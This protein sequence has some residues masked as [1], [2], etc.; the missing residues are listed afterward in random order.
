MRLNEPITNREVEMRDGQ[1]LV[2]QTDAGGRIT[3]VN[4]AFIDI[5]GFSEAEL[6]GQPHNLVRHPHMPKE[7]FRDLWRTIQSGAPWEGYV[8]NRTKT[9]DYYWVHANVTP[10]VENGKVAGFISIRTK[11]SR[12]SV[13]AAD[14]A[15]AAIRSGR[16]KRLSVENGKAVRLGLAHR[17]ATVMAGL[18]A[19]MSAVGALV[20]IAVLGLAGN[21]LYGLNVSRLD[22]ETLYKDRVVPLGQLDKVEGAMQSEIIALRTALDDLSEGKAVGD[23]TQALSEYDSGA[24]AQWDAYMATYLTPEESELAKQLTEDRETVRHDIMPAAIDLAKAGDVAAL[25]SHLREIIGPHFAKM[26][27]DMTALKQLQQDVSAEIYEDS[28]AHFNFAI[29]ETVVVLVAI[30]ALLMLSGVW[31]SRGVTRPLRQF[32]GDLDAMSAGN[33]A[34]EIKSAAIREFDRLATRLRAV[35]A[36]LAYGLEERRERDARAAEERA[37]SLHKMADQIREQIGA[38]VESVSKVT[39]QMA[40][41]AGEM[42]TS[43]GTVSDRAQAVAAA[44]TEALANVQTVASASE[45][46]SASISE[47]AAQVNSAQKVTTDSVEAASNAQTIIAKL[48]DAVGRIGQVTSL[49]NDIAGQ[50]NLLALNATIEAA[51]AGEA[52]KGFA[53]VAGEVKSLATQ[54]SRATGDISTQIAEVQAAT[55]SVVTAVQTIVDSIKNVEGISTAIAAAI[56]EQNATTAEIARNVTQTS[57]A[58]QEVAARISEVSEESSKTGS[59]AESVRGMSTEVAK[60]VDGVSVGLEQVVKSALHGIERPRKTRH[61]LREP[62]KVLADSATTS[63]IV[64]NIS[65]GGAVLHG[66]TPTV[67]P[68]EKLQVAIEGF[69]EPVP[70]RVVKAK[71]GI[72]HVKFD[73]TPAISQRFMADFQ[74]AVSGKRVVGA[75]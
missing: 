8:K 36:K 18:T 64:E 34:H 55:D 3:F 43:A 22:I 16:D 46:L 60:S 1:L 19:R 62:G 73:L 5:S 21:G 6:V 48:S 70:A 33:T 30:L 52:G 61:I 44:A 37:E 69:S 75:A 26:Q 20:L 56:D 2:S 23:L 40:Q 50:T 29:V 12:E 7:A 47:I 63:M 28:G 4:Q 41:D 38:A 25:R 72:L 49:I 58:A 13:K 35:R 31:L 17:I 67:K 27:A 32:E 66:A 57:I 15:Y 51:R 10:V 59:R 71:N 53:V 45:E 65:E 9:G 68:G 11:P 39:G 74:K 54:T 24:Q 14:E 42:S